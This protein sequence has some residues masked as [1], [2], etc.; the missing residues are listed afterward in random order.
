MRISNFCRLLVFSLFVAVN[1]GA[2][3]L[4]DLNQI[5]FNVKQKLLRE[6]SNRYPQAKFDIEVSR[7]DPRLRL[8][9]CDEPLTLNNKS[10]SQNA[11][12]MTV[13]VVCHGSTPWSLYISSRIQQWMPVVISRRDLIKGV[14]LTEADLTTEVRDIRRMNSGF[15]TD[16]NQIIGM[17]VRRPLKAGEGLR[18]SSLAP[19]LLVEKGDQ[20]TVIASSGNF[21]VKIA[22][23]AL[24]KGKLGDQIRVQN[25]A[26]EKVIKARVI[27]KGQVSVT[28]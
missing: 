19:P 8:A 23:I 26:T 1:A 22:G 2:Q 12:N 21:S 27:E 6:L 18:S 15:I 14:H 20:V 24:T 9:Q 16:K 3:G 17:Q 25:T 13:Q 28:L 11:S 10:R 7:L 5:S 4:Q